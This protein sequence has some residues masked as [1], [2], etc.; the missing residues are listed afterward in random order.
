MSSKGSETAVLEPTLT[1]YDKRVLKALDFFDFGT[2]LRDLREHPL[3]WRD[4][5]DIGR[6]LKE[7]D[8]DAL[9]ATLRG[10]EHLHYVWS[11]HFDHK[12]VWTAIKRAD[13]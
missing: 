10:L 11:Q 5:W 3:E 1:R 13:A 8:L 4:L 2:G 7:R 12:R 9:L 6:R